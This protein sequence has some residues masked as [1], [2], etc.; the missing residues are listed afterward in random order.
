MRHHIKFASL[1]S[2]VLLLLGSSEGG[3]VCRRMDEFQFR[4]LARLH[5]LDYR[6]PDVTFE[7][8][9]GAWSAGIFLL[10]TT[11]RVTFATQG[12]CQD[13]GGHR[14]CVNYG[15]Y[16]SNDGNKYSN[17]AKYSIAYNTYEKKETF[18]AMR[19][20]CTS[21]GVFCF[22]VWGGMCYWYYMNMTWS[23]YC[24]DLPILNFDV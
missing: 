13:L 19:K 8:Q 1:V 2:S 6:N 7:C 17:T 16:V 22:D 20:I 18:D 21:D 4:D 24:Q 14:A 5:D 15:G 9:G 3:S 10:R 11:D 23:K 12:D